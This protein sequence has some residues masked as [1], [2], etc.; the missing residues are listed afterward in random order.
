MTSPQSTAI[1]R[2]ARLLL[3][4]GGLIS[5]AVAGG[6]T[7]PARPYIVPALALISITTCSVLVL[8]SKRVDA[9]LRALGLRVIIAAHAIRFIGASFLWVH[10]RGFLPARF[11]YAAGIGDIVTA[12]GAL[13]LLQLPEGPAFRRVLLVWNVLGC[14]DL[15][16]ALRTAITLNLTQ[17]GSMDTMTTLPWVWIP[18]LLVPLM[19]ASH[20]KIFQWLWLERSRHLAL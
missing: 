13:L 11:A 8:R 14:L 2:L 1:A 7:H 17:P 12:V 16:N 3:I 4:W 6:L 20:L 5:A 10:E 19:S 18:R 15:L 9:D